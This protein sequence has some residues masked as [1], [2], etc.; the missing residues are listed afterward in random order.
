M[1]LSIGV[2]EAGRGPWAGPVFAGLVVL[3]DEQEKVLIEAGVTDSKKVTAKKRE[4]LFEL[5]LRNSTFAKV[6]YY[7]IDIIDTIGIYKATKE[8]IKQLVLELN[9]DFLFEN[10]VLIDGLFPKF[11]LLN[12]KQEVV[13][14]ECIIKGD[15]KVTS[16]AAASILAKVRRDKFMEELDK[17]YPDYQF[18][19]HKGYGTKLH[20]DLLQK[21]G[22]CECHRKSFKPVKDLQ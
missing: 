9:E 8:L 11:V 17:K 12:S 20:F 15:S 6:K 21:L 5:I 19:K 1:K 10:K 16:I 3:N 22:P 7:D 13:T 14:H 4:N 18:A 2:D